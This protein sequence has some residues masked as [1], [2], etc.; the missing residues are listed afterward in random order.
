MDPINLDGMTLDDLQD[1]EPV[2][3]LY[4]QYAE[5]KIKAMQARMSGRIADALDLEIA[6][7]T[8]YQQLPADAR[9]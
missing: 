2:L 8:T 7:E 1:L 6:C 4:W 3:L 9:W 5:I